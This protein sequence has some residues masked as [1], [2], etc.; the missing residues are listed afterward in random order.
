MSMKRRWRQKME[1]YER[2]ASSCPSQQPSSFQR[3][4]SQTKAHISVPSS[5]EPHSPISL[6]MARLVES[7]KRT[8]ESRQCV[9]RQCMARLVDSMKRT[10]ESRRCVML[11]RELLFAPVQRRQLTAT[12]VKLR[13]WQVEA[14]SRKIRNVNGPKCNSSLVRSANR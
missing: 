3:L 9:M 4:R 5:F 8:R 12:K 11:Q 13:R 1:M 14:V 10:G 7:M 2:S 6:Q